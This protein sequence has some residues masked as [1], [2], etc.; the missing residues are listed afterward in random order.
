M[1]SL[2]MPSRRACHL[3]NSRRAQFNKY[4]RHHEGSWFARAQFLLAVLDFTEQARLSVN[5]QLFET[6]M[7]ALDG[8]LGSRIHDDA[9]RAHDALCGLGLGSAGFSAEQ[10]SPFLKIEQDETS[11]ALHLSSN[12]VHPGH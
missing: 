9:G 5:A 11:F 8:I 2:Q 1:H 6:L 7:S 3:A 10:S 4:K 12:T